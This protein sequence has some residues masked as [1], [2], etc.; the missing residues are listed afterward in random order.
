M[1]K[2][3]NRICSFCG[4]GQDEVKLIASEGSH[5]YICDKCV[6]LCNEILQEGK[7]EALA[8]SSNVSRPV[9]LKE[10]LVS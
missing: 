2:D 7:K 3:I 1:K 6:A 8:I 5:V 9:E 4:K 10:L